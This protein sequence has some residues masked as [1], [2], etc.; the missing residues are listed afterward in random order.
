MK[1]V[2]IR[3]WML[4][5]GVCTLVGGSAPL[6]AQ[7]G[8]TSIRAIGARGPY[9]ASLS[10]GT[11]NYDAGGDRYFPFLAVRVS[12]PISEF[13]VAEVGLGYAPVESE[14]PDDPTRTEPT[15]LLLPDIMLHFEFPLGPVRP[16]LGAGVGLVAQLEANALRG[17]FVRP[18]Y[19]GAGGFRMAMSDRI[20]LRGDLRVRLDTHP[21]FMAFDFEHSLGVGVRF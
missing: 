10:A 15:Q 5:G 2:A 14:T 4:L 8:A 19:A 6:G 1:V 17:R 9:T 16:Y 20:E 7:E 21:G 12:R 18:S 13:F 11:F 3:R